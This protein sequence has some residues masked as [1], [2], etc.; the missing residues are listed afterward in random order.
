MMMRRR[1]GESMDGV[2]GRRDQ[3]QSQA[4]LVERSRCE[5]PLENSR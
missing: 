4:I 3:A 1:G 2:Q 5:S